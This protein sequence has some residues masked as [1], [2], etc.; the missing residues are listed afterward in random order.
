MCYQ[1]Y[2]TINC[3]LTVKLTQFFF[4][5]YSWKHLRYTYNSYIY[6]FISSHFKIILLHFTSIWIDMMNQWPVQPSFLLQ[7]SIHMLAFHI[8]ATSKSVQIWS[9][10]CRNLGINTLNMHICYQLS[11]KG[12]LYPG[13]HTF[14]TVNFP[15]R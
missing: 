3:M 7:T 4:D 9:I 10:T 5:D 13:P 12:S 8:T 1:S 2:L 15:S 11:G 6:L 14:R